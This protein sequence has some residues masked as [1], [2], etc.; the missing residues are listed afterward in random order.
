LIAARAVL[1]SPACLSVITG[2]EQDQGWEALVAAA[3]AAPPGRAA[4]RRR[5]ESPRAAVAALTILC[6][7]M[8]NFHKLITN[9]ITYLFFLLLFCD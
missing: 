5:G 3:A 1:I 9:D 7:T 2:K 4:E 8:C 6:I